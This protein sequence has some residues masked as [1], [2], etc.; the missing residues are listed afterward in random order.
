MGVAIDQYGMV[1]EALEQA[2]RRL[3]AQGE[4]GRVKAIYLVPYFDNPCGVTM[5]LERRARIVEIA[6]R[7]SRTNGFT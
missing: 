2:L 5:P 6:R 1:P 4:L 3:E 7:W